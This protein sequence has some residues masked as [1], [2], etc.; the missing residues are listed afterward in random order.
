MKL[1]GRWLALTF[2]ALILSCTEGTKVSGTATDTENTI[3]GTVLLSDSSLAG[4]VLV[5]Q[6]AARSASS[7]IY[8]ETVTDSTGSFSFDSTLADTV[9]MEFRYGAENSGQI[10]AQLVRSLSVKTAQPLDVRLEDAVRLC[11]WLDYA[12]DTANFAGSH[13]HVLLDSTTFAVD[14]FAPDSFEIWVPSGNYSLTILPADTNSVSK[15]QSAG[16]ADSAIIRKMDISVPPGEK[17]DVGKLRWDPS[18]KEPL[19]SK[20]LQGVVVD[21]NGSPVKGAAVHVVADIYG[22][23]ASEKDGFTTEVISDSEGVWRIAAPASESVIDSFRVEARG[24]DSSGQNL[25]GVSAYIQKSD[26]ENPADTLNAD[27]IRLQQSASFRTQLYWTKAPDSTQC[28]GGEIRVGFLGTDNFEIVGACGEV[29]M[30]DLPSGSQDLVL[31]VADEQMIRRLKSGEILPGDLVQRVSVG[32]IAGDTLQY[33]DLNFAP[34]EF[35]TDPRED[36][37]R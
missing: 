6:V 10:Q 23:G 1:D 13:F 21:E 9:N 15:M 37:I 17:L 24:K 12:G 34:P 19:R 3:A 32:L 22:F 26:L 5:R 27:T 4:G 16:Y 31:Y 11:G 7:L 28:G 35:Q 14:L 30:Q 2:C 20:V 29:F 33:S 18:R 36:E 25:A 8:L